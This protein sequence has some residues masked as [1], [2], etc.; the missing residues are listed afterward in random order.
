[1]RMFRYTGGY[2]FL[3]FSPSTIHSTVRETTPGVLW[4]HTRDWS[5]RY[6]ISKP[7]GKGSRS[8]EQAINRISR[9]CR[10]LLHI[11]ANNIAN[12][13]IGR[14]GR[15]WERGKNFSSSLFDRPTSHFLFVYS[16]LFSSFLFFHSHFSFR[17]FEEGVPT[18]HE[19]QRTTH[20]RAQRYSTSQDRADQPDL[21][22]GYRLIT[23][24]GYLYASVSFHPYLNFYLRPFELTVTDFISRGIFVAANEREMAPL[25]ETIDAPSNVFWT[26]FALLRNSRTLC[27]RGPIEIWISIV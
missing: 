7:S 4:G 22:G 18:C 11:L 12:D 14:E 2:Y 23:K 13:A 16:S 26:F 10:P 19:G 25:E 24:R 21:E 15:R 5:L 17:G 3:Y 8:R 27:G 20:P 9:D 1:M 6:A